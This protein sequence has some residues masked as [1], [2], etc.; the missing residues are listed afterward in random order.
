MGKTAQRRL[1]S[2]DHDR[3]VRVKLF[4]YFRIDRNRAVGPQAGLAAGR[5]RIFAAAALGG[6]IMRHHGINIAARDQEAEPRAAETAKILR[7]FPIRLAKHCHTVTRILQHARN[8]GCAEAGMVYISIAA[9]VDKICLLPAA[10][11]HLLCRDRQKITFLRH[12]FHSH[13]PA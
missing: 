10:R 2:T 4:Q 5:I 7:L 13:P 6:G 8:N 12:R 1:Q 9:D 3:A 11:M